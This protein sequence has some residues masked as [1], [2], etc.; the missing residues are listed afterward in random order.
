MPVSGS[1]YSFLCLAD[2]VSKMQVS[3][4]LEVWGTLRCPLGFIISK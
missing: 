2:Q 1:S 3:V 4:F